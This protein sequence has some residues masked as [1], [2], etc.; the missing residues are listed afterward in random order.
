MEVNLTQQAVFYRAAIAVRQVLRTTK[1][2]A[3]PPRLWGRDRRLP[4]CAASLDCPTDCPIFW[5]T[6]RA[7]S[8]ET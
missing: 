1:F 6:N 4:T 8:V 7:G 2:G 5:V 3:E